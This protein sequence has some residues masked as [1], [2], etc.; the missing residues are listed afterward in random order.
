MNRAAPGALQHATTCAA[1]ALS[2]TAFP[3]AAS[4]I[5]AALGALA[6]AAGIGRANGRPRCPAL[7]A[8]VSHAE[9][10]ATRSISGCHQLCRN[11]ASDLQMTR[12]APSVRASAFPTID[13]VRSLLSIG[14]VEWAC[15][16]EETFLRFC[17]RHSRCN[18]G[19]ATQKAKDPAHSLQH[20][21][22]P[23]DMRAPTVAS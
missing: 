23:F 15:Q 17:L 20:E 14:H 13:C 10:P 21:C 6:A 3:Q 16:V 9:R 18:S 11:A 2:R 19:R 12:P 22:S 8:N 4:A 1:F 7:C 5:R